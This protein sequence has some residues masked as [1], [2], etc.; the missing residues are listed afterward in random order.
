MIIVD[1]CSKK[2]EVPMFLI[3][4][5]IDVVSSKKTG[6]ICTFRGIRYNANGFAVLSTEHSQ[7]DYLLPMSQDA[8]LVFFEQ[9]TELIRENVRGIRLTGAPVYRVRRGAML[10]M[11][12][13]TSC[14]YQVS[15]I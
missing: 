3:Y 2:K 6:E 4:D 14:R 1:D 10:P 7:H 8:Y 9:T 5:C 13:K 15:A 11:D 12:D